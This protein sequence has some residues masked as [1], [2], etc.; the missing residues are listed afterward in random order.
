MKQIYNPLVVFL[1]DIL[2]EMPEN[3][4]NPTLKNLK[5]NGLTMKLVENY[6]EVDKLD[7]EF[8]GFFIW[9]LCKNI[10][11]P[12]KPDDFDNIL[13][14]CLQKA[15]MAIT[16]RTYIKHNIKRFSGADST[17]SLVVLAEE[18]IDLVNVQNS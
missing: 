16:N 6:L 4:V 12:H 3:L 2:T 15:F 7:Y 14:K 8:I 18:L 17:N 9:F 13:E 11:C 10:N 5:E 1:D